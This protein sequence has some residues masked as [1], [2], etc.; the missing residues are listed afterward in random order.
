MKKLAFLVLISLAIVSCSNNALDPTKY[1]VTTDKISL[2]DSNIE[3]YRVSEKIV[4]AGTKVM[5]LQ[6]QIHADD[7]GY[8]R[9]VTAEGHDFG[10]VKMSTIKKTIEPIMFTS[11]QVFE[12]NVSEVFYVK[13]SNSSSDRTFQDTYDLLCML[14]AATCRIDIENKN[15]EV[16]QSVKFK[17]YSGYKY[18]DCKI[19]LKNFKIGDNELTVIA[20]DKYD[21]IVGTREFV[22]TKDDSSSKTIT[23]G[24]QDNFMYH[25]LNNE[26]IIDRFYGY[27]DNDEDMVNYKPDFNL[28]EIEGTDGYS[29]NLEIRLDKSKNN[30]NDIPLTLSVMLNNQEQAKFDLDHYE[31]TPS[32]GQAKIVEYPN[33]VLFYCNPPFEDAARIVIYN[34]KTNKIYDIWSLLKQ[35]GI[36]GFHSAFVVS[37]EENITIEEV[38]FHFDYSEKNYVN[39][40]V[41]INTYKILQ[42]DELP[43]K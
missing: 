28:Y 24:Q 39:Y 7:K 42:I 43:V 2:I 40:V 34:K 37:V 12:K 18:A 9:I 17:N 22:L 27:S 23:N 32:W 4:E 33:A 21:E 38:P 26:I 5:L 14:S 8:V 31:L 35:N 10:F 11:K 15:G 6:N 3:F 16:I 30:I 25:A 1:Y 36:T 19:D 41:D 20:Y 13:N 29:Y